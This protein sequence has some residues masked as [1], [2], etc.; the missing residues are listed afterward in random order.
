MPPE[1]A[2]DPHARDL[3]QA[4]LDSPPPGPRISEVGR[5]LE[6]VDGIAIVTGLS[7]AL[8]DEVLEFASGVRG[9]VFDLETD[10]LGVVLLGPPDRVQPGEH[11]RRT[12][13]VLSV[14]AGPALLGRVVDALGRP[15]DGRCGATSATRATDSWGECATAEQNVFRPVYPHG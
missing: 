7:W 14:P 2:L 15:R 10:R 5:V 8:A 3:V 6:V 1:A 13:R 12:R 4:L 9:V 11:A